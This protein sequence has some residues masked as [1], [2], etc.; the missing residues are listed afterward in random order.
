MH[1]ASE[2]V[3]GGNVQKG[4]SGGPIFIPA[5]TTSGTP[6]GKILGILSNYGTYGYSDYVDGKIILSFSTAFCYVPAASITSALG[7]SVA[8]K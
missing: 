8:A 2:D 5:T 1:P 3:I 6:A 7:I 4:D